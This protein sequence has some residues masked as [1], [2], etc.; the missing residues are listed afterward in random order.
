MILICYFPLV[1]VSTVIANEIND[2][3]H[4]RVAIEEQKQTL[5]K[6]KQDE[7]KA[8]YVIFIIMTLV[9]QIFFFPF[10][11]TLF[12]WMLYSIRTFYLH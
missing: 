12:F 1:Y 6:F 2:L 10:L 4:E 3:E 9:F 5:K 7:L 11:L 8:E